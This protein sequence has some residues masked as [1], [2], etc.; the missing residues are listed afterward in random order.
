MVII[1][2]TI[3][4]MLFERPMGVPSLFPGIEGVDLIVGRK[5]G[6]HYLIDLHLKVADEMQVREAHFLGHQVKDWVMA[7][8]PEIVDIVVH[9]EPED[10]FW[11]A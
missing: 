4:F 10:Q 2:C 7:E 6:M 9:M 11:K 1:L 8:M 3:R 5:S